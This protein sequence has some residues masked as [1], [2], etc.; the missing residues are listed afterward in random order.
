VSGGDT[1][2]PDGVTPAETPVD[3]YPRSSLVG[4]YR[5]LERIGEG[6]MGLVYA[7]YDAELDR[8]IA[9]K[10]V[11]PF[12]GD[13]AASARRARLVREGKAMARIAHPNVITV[14]DAGTRGGDVFIAMELVEGL[15]LRAWLAAKPRPFRQI[16]DVFLQAGRGLAAAHAAGLVH[17]DFKPDNVLVRND[18][19][20]LVTDFGLVRGEA[21]EQSGSGA[22]AATPAA[23]VASVVTSN[24]LTEA[25]VILGTPAYMS[26]EQ[27]RGEVAD[28]R[29]DQFAFCTA[30][31]E[32]LYHGRPFRPQA[33]LELTSLEALALEVV[34]GRIQPEPAG[35]DVPPWVRRALVRGLAAAPGDRW[36]SMT[37]LLTAL[38]ADPAARRKRHWFVGLGAAALLGL[39]ALAVLGLRPGAA[40]ASVCDDGSA[41]LAGMWDDAR[42]QALHAAF[43]A[44]GQPFAEDAWRATRADLDRWTGAFTAMVRENCAASR[45]RHE[46]SDELYDLRAACLAR[47]R[48][49]AR[50]LLGVLAQVD[51]ATLH[52]AFAV[53]D[54]LPE[55]EACADAAALRTV[56]PPPRDPAARAAIEQ[57]R[58][59]VAQANAL[60]LAGRYQE[61]LA[62]AR[63]ARQ[64]ADRLGY[65][66]LQA[67]AAFTTAELESDSGDSKTAVGT[68]AVAAQLAA[69]AHA[70]AT[71]I[72]VLARQ[73]FVYAL[74]LG[75]REHAVAAADAAQLIMLRVGA[76]D[77][78]RAGLLN[79]RIRIANLQGRYDEGLA[80]AQLMM[81][82]NLRAHGP[83][84]R[85]V[86]RSLRVIGLELHQKLLLPQAEAAFSRALVAIEAMLGP[87][88]PEV[89]AVLHELGGVE[90]ESGKFAEARP[91]IERSLDIRRRTLGPDHVEVAVTL[92]GLASL[93]LD[94]E[95][96]AAAAQHA[97][98][99]LEIEERALGPLHPNLSFAL[100]V[101]GEVERKQGRPEQAVA[102]DVRALAIREKAFGAD[103]ALVAEALVFLALAQLDG[104]KPLE[105]LPLA[106][107]A[108]ALLVAHESDLVDIATARFAIARALWD[109]GQ[110]RARARALIEQVRQAAV[111]AGT[112]GVMLGKDVAIWLEA[113]TS[114]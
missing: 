63:V 14:Y 41:R 34:S 64:Q 83:G 61:G 15:T 3:P 103:H 36:P 84:H 26:P 38:S 102:Y 91:H 77:A 25:G 78:R 67:E 11:R 19:R 100:L 28:E 114:R 45:V 69:Q 93:D 79:A 54:G 70:D 12:G 106:T 2:Q 37:E 104:K 90:R 62:V 27:H 87:N 98:E 89:S 51:R 107:H 73:S 17:R 24:D 101:L 86:V 57:A 112:R 109:S 92:T 74:R 35:T 1:T 5:I 95:N 56:S 52:R 96:F 99:A 21:D 23:A 13:D 39:V 76:D 31:Y 8:K 22:A 72:D 6:A 9:L 30:L 71:L 82:L 43:V 53:A 97:R 47:R 108:E 88:H 32:A 40:G 66:P 48:D 20:A 75:D 80:L 58:T 94:T 105:A 113:H 55:L 10:L 65:A 33:E 81:E 16:L 60:R 110:D 68:Y 50:E 59:Q 85:S 4:R 44:T 42:R 29:S 46:Q 18:G 49:E 111:A 7:A